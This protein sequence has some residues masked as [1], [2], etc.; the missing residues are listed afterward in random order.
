[1]S[2]GAA[3]T[4][5]LHIP[6]KVNKAYREA[7]NARKKAY[8][9][10]SKFKVGAAVIGRKIF[11]GCNIENASFGATY[12]AERTAIVKAVSSGEKSFSDIVIVTNKASTPPCGLCLQSM[13][14]FCRGDSRIWL[15]N[16]KKITRA[17]LLSELLTHPFGPNQLLK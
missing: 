9:P 4:D 3:M 12:C 5:R 16:E 8:A 14:E 6:L 15:G 11:S 13:A 10:Y 17:Y 7:R 2:L 1:M